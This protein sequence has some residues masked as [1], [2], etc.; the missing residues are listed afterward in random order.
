MNSRKSPIILSATLLTFCLF[1]LGCNLGGGN[2]NNATNN[3][4]S[5][6]NNTASSTNNTTSNTNNQSGAGN[7]SSPATSGSPTAS[8][9]PLPNAL[10]GGSSWVQ[11]A[12]HPDVEGQIGQRFTYTC[13][14]NTRIYEGVSVA[15]DVYYTGSSLCSAAF[16]AGV[17]TQAQGGPITIEIRPAPAT[18]YTAGEARNGVTPRALNFNNQSDNGGFVFVR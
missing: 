18:S 17:I 4:I 13:P 1:A 14:P 8:P 6:T 9:M 15:G 7:S 5:N 2:T 11:T 16:H 3:T 10:T 12:G